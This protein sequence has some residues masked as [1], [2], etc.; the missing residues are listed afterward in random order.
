[1]EVDLDWTPVELQ[2]AMKKRIGFRDWNSDAETSWG[3]SVGNYEIA[4]GL[5]Q[6]HDL[7][8]RVW[9][10]VTFHTARDVLDACAANDALT[11]NVV[12]W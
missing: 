2:K 1:M 11:V 7:D 4:T 3:L 12:L 8:S 6:L 5:F 9:K 10:T